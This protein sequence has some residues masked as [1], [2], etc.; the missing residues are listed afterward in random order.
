MLVFT[1][2]H[3]DNFNPAT[4]DVVWAQVEGFAWEDYGPHMFVLEVDDKLPPQGFLVSGEEPPP[5]YTY[6]VT[7]MSDKTWVSVAPCAILRWRYL[8]KMGQV[9]VPPKEAI[10]SLPLGAVDVVDHGSLKYTFSVCGHKVGVCFR[11][12]RVL[13]PPV[14]GDEESAGKLCS[15]LRMHLFP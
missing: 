13:V 5:G 14:D 15:I 9:K 12:L 11:S 3:T 8:G 1:R 4:R 7:S 6:G 2:Q 10:E